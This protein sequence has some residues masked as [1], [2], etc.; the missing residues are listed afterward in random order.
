MGGAIFCPVPVVVESTAVV[1]D[2]VV[3]TYIDEAVFYNDITA[4]TG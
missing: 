4:F 3:A 1:V 2:V